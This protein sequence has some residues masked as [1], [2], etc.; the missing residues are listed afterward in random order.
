MTDIE[1]QIFA[2]LTLHEALLSI[3]ISQYW[4]ASTAEDEEM[5]AANLRGLLRQSWTSDE[6]ADPDEVFSMLTDMQNFA[7]AFIKKTRDKAAKLR[8]NL[9]DQ[10]DL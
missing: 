8:A 3:V 7:D 6:S 5:A 10:G 1:Q 4:G 2:R 9:A